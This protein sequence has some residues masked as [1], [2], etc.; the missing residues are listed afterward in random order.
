MDKKT[1]RVGKISEAIDRAKV[2]L[3]AAVTLLVNGFQSR[4][5]LSITAAG[6]VWV[7]MRSMTLAM[8]CCF[9]RPSASA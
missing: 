6:I 7:T 5:G 9:A 3:S 8:V 1:I 2:P 4:W